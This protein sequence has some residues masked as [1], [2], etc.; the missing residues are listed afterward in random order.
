MPP[1]APSDRQP[2]PP[3]KPLLKWAGGKRWLAPRLAAAWHDHRHRRLV[4][5]CCGGLAV[6]LALRPE[7]ALLNDRNPQLIALYRC[8][9]RGLSLDLPMRNE[10]DA[11]Y[12]ARARFNQLI[13]A[14]LGESAEAA[15]HAIYLNRTCFNGLWRCNARGHF[16][17]PFGR[18]TA[19]TYPTDLTAYH[20]AFAPWTF[21]CASFES[22]PLDPD[23]FIYADPPYH[24]PPGT[25][26]A[27]AGQTLTWDQQ[28]ALATRLAGHPGPVLLSNRAT[29]A[30]LALYHELGYDLL[31]L[32]GP[33]AINCTG[34]RTP[35]LEVLAS[36][37]LAAPR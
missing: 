32:P 23:D 37:G 3:L 15:Q 4:E 17:V 8:I 21:S 28:V 26:T 18:Y 12:A 16:N 19:I 7:R 11:Y 34:D 13:G 27:Y 5:L 31:T 33:R 9:Q 30:I 6:S 35:A 25:F 1:S 22:V 24:G 36:R 20:Q 14:G 10:R 2:A 29:P